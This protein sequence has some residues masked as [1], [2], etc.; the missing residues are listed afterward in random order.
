[1]LRTRSACFREEEP[2]PPRLGGAL[3]PDLTIYPET[4]FQR[5]SAESTA[6]IADCGNVA[7]CTAT[8]D[9]TTPLLASI[10][11]RSANE[12]KFAGRLAQLVRAPR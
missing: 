10:V 1:M 5:D 6:A 12:R 7:N 8:A 2:L 11:V 3:Q 4:D 9:L